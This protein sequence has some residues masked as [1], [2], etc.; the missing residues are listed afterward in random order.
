MSIE[1]K[2]KWWRALWSPPALAL[3]A[4]IGLGFA[5]QQLVPTTLTYSTLKNESLLNLKSYDQNRLEL[6][7]DNAH[8]Q[9]PFLAEVEIKNIGSKPIRPDLFTDQFGNCGI[10]LALSV[11]GSSCNVLACDVTSMKPANR[12]PIAVKILPPLGRELG[13]RSNVF[14]SPVALN[15]GESFNLRLVTDGE[16]TSIDLVGH[17]TDCNI[18]KFDLWKS[19]SDLFPAFLSVFQFTGALIAFL[20][21]AGV[22]FLVYCLFAIWEVIKALGKMFSSPPKLESVVSTPEQAAEAL[23]D[24]GSFDELATKLKLTTPDERDGLRKSLI[25]IRKKPVVDVIENNKAIVSPEETISE[26][27]VQEVAEAENADL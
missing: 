20:L 19:I 6:R 21:A 13:R 11:G 3:F 10:G 24:D 5:Y 12:A 9:S 2:F 15:P 22:L 7:F 8:V 18:Q 26:P 4:V 16:P 27:K 1:S 17:I 23:L 25:Q 14:I